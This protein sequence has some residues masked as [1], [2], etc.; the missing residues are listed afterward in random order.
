MDRQRIQHP[1]HPHDDVT[2]LCGVST[3]EAQPPESDI[4]HMSTPLYAYGIHKPAFSFECIPGK[5]T[6]HAKH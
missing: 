2:D 6:D 1:G 5:D 3:Q 4:L